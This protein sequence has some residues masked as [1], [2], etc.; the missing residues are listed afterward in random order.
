MRLP[1]GPSG[2][3]ARSTLHL[4]PTPDCGIKED[5]NRSLPLNF[6]NDTP[7]PMV[8]LSPMDGV[9]DACVRRIVATHGRPDLIVTEFTSVEGNLN[10]AASE[11]GGLIFDDVE[12]PIVAQIYGARP[13][14]LYAIAQLVCELG[15]EG[16]D[17]NM[18]CPAKA[19]S[20]RGCGA[21][22]IKDPARAKAILQAARAGIA[23]WVGGAPLALLGV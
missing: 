7:K 3:G 23:D 14:S 13:E 16:G 8:A 4:K 10:G 5:S 22:L 19:V 20:S 1:V 6:W 21:G 2:A 17:S 18:G 15:F 12:R 11:L 9:T